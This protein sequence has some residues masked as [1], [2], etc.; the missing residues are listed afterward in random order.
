MARHREGDVGGDAFEEN[1]R[2][3]VRFLA[4]RRKVLLQ[5]GED[6]PR[7]PRSAR[8]G[9]ALRWRGAW[10]GWRALMAYSVSW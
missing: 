5:R 6:L 3:L 4:V 7:V 1:L 8:A 2:F 9:S 10:G